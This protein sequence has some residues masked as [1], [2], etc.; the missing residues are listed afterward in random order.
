MCVATIKPEVYIVR[1][2][3]D[4]V[5]AR[6][7]VADLAFSSSKWMKNENVKLLKPFLFHFS[8]PGQNG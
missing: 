1:K 4:Q 3:L 6:V 7:A 8:R 5:R 2:C